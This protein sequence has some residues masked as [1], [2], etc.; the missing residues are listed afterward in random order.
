MEAGNVYWV[1][2]VTSPDGYIKEKASD[3]SDKYYGPFVI[4]ARG[5]IRNGQGATAQ[6]VD[7][8]YI[9]TNKKV[10]EKNKLL[11]KKVADGASKTPL[12]DEIGRAHV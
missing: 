6:K 12:E 7:Q 8:P 11:L 9:V 5:I 4:N 1:R 2:E 3:G 10:N